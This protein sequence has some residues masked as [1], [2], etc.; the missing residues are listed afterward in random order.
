MRKSTPLEL[1]TITVIL[2]LAAFLRIY[3]L[4]TIP[5]GLTVDEAMR[6]YDAYSILRTGK[7]SFGNVSIFLR[8]FEDYTPALYTYLTIPFVAIFNLSAYSTRLAAAL[9]GVL[10]VA[11]SYQ[12]IRRPFGQ[13]AALIGAFLLAISP[14]H[15]ISSRT[16][17]EW[18]LLSL[19]PVLTIALAYR[20]LTR[21]RYLIAAG[22]VAGITLYGYAPTKAFLPVLITGFVFFYWREL[23]RQKRAALIALIAFILIATPLYIFSFSPRGMNRFNHVYEGTD[24]SLSTIAPQL[25][26]NYFS[27]FSPKFFLLK[28]Y[29]AEIKPPMP[30]AHLRSVGLFSWFEFFL[31]ILGLVKIFFLRRKS[32]WFMLY[33]LLAA[34][35]GI[36]LHGN[37]PWP[38]LWLTVIPVPQALAGA[39]FAW[40]LSLAKYPRVK[41]GPRPWKLPPWLVRSTAIVL[42]LGFTLGI[43]THFKTVYSDLFYEFPVYGAKAWFSGPGPAIT[44]MATLKDQYDEVDLIANSLESSIYILFYTR[45]DPAQRHAELAAD[46]EDIWQNIDNY[47]LGEIEDYLHLP[48]CHLILTT[49]AN[50]EAIRTQT[51][52][53][54][55]LRQF[56]LSD[57][58]PTFGLYAFPSPSPTVVEQGTVFGNQIMLQGFAATSTSGSTAN[59]SP[60]QSV[61]LILQWQALEKITTDYTVFIHLVGPNN[62]ATNSP[63]WAQH[64]SPPMH[65]IS[66]TSTWDVGDV[67]QDPHRIIIPPDIPSGQYTLQAGLYNSFTGERLPMQLSNGQTDDKTILMELNIQDK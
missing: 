5:N 16:G 36:N 61:C 59:V 3:Q 41:P 34:P 52:H 12:V 27:Y 15:I 60:G 42:L 31:I 28:D 11:L 1:L 18:N 37:S 64:D 22:I 45:H 30:L 26:K 47:N 2:L 50:G 9:V 67:I 54:I 10:V 46:P 13:T 20:G 6:G 66:P 23:R 38:T 8:G 4:D 14:W 49:V 29:G 7:D 33:W 51:P 43:L 53:L 62:Q 65:N 40:L 48:G 17:A 32:A 56:E 44:T 25:I 21:P 35:I 58:Q 57:G 24:D 19:A 39:G 55:T 63:L